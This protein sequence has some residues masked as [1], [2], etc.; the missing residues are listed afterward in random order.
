MPPSRR[1][2]RRRARK[3]AT[4]ANACSYRS[5]IATSRARRRAAATRTSSSWARQ[6]RTRSASS[7]VQGQAN[8]T[9]FDKR[10]CVPNAGGPAK[11]ER[12]DQPLLGPGARPTLG[13]NGKP[14]FNT[15]RAGGTN[16]DCQFID[17]S[18]DTNGG[19]VPGYAMAQS[20]TI[21]LTYTDG[22]SRPP[23]V[24]RPGAGRD[25]RDDVRPVVGR[26]RVHRQHARRRAAGDAI[27]R[28]RPVPV[29]EPGEH[30][31]RRL[32]PARSAG[33][34]VP[35]LHGGP[36]GTRHGADGRHRAMLCNL[37][38]YWHSST[39]SAAATTAAAINSC[40]AQPAPPDTAT[41][42][43]TGMNCRGKWYTGMQGWFH[44]AWFTDEARYLFTHNGASPCSSTAT[45]TCSSSSTAS[46][47]STW[48]A[49]TSGCPDGS[50]SAARPA[51]RRSPRADRWM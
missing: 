50:T 6:S 24:P 13:A 49:S 10:Y 17:W 41:T 4:A 28:R 34:R 1:T 33:S 51:W 44:D 20:P 9:I 23:D 14:T 46:S 35:A 7:G 45:T 16:C 8:P 43:P 19:H 18:H 5:S 40:S 42:C 11:E 36:S 31:D 12:R 29:L 2:T 27:D 15:A 30:G 32:L 48:A 26:Q 37:W 38:P 22:A 25:Q 39:P 3:A 47:S 21:G